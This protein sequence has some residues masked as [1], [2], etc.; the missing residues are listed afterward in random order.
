MT[1]SAKIIDKINEFVKRQAALR[2]TIDEP[3]APEVFFSLEFFPPKTDLGKQNLYDRMENM[4]TQQ[5]IFVDVTWGA[6]GKTKDLTMSICDYT[7]KYLGVDVLM[8]LTLTGM[9]VAKLKDILAQAKEAG[10]RNILALRGDPPA[11]V[12]IWEPTIDGLYHAIDLVKL[13]RSE[14]GDYFCIACAGF[15]EG[16]PVDKHSPTKLESSGNADQDSYT[17]SLTHLK[18]K[19]DAGVDFI[20]TQFFYDPKVFLKFLNDCRE[21]GIT[22]PIIP[23]ML[24]IQNYKSFEKMTAYCKSK[25][26][27]AI[28]QAITPIK[29]DDEAVKAYGVT[30]CTQM[31]RELLEAG[32]IQGFHFYTLNLEKSVMSVMKELGIEATLSSRRS[33]PWRGSRSNLNGSKEDVRPINWA[34]RPKSYMQRTREWYLVSHQFFICVWL[35][36]YTA[37]FQIIKTHRDE[38]PNGR[39]GDSRSPAFGELSSTHT[40]FRTAL[41]TNVQRL[42]MWGGRIRAFF[43]FVMILL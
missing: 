11:G 42:T 35:F 9:T 15:P 2:D 8:H 24:P 29:E 12:P 21:I 26:P 30:Q 37:K 6:G 36:I 28:W 14:Y 41:G 32:C 22:C 10:I 40:F 7:Q 17:S 16:H 34:N 27:E 23:G 25:V 31:C 39:W 13:I 20:L 4:I 3:G 5:P 38:F 1:T 19:V 18:A 43:Y 33:M